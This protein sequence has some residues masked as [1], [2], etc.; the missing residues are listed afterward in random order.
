MEVAL[1]NMRVTFQKNTV[2]ADEIGNHRNE[3]TDVYSC[4]ATVSGESPNENTDAGM[5]VDD[6]KVDF[7]VRWCRAVSDMTN[8]E[9]R[10]RYQGAIYNILGIDHMNF[11][12]K[13]VKFK[14]QKGEAVAWERRFLFSQLQRRLWRLSGNMRIQQQRR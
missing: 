14:C 5:V 3:W 10:I 2:I 12:R 8:T 6:S 7:T 9:Y 4:Y 11:K 13:A 1:L